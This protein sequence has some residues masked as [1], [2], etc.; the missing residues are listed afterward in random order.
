MLK[1]GLSAN[2]TGLKIKIR[3]KAKLLIPAVNS[4]GESQSVVKKP[5]VRHY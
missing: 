4:S 2:F 5:V 3:L 1:Y